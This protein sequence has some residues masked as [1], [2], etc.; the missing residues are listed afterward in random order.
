M[1][2][3]STIYLSVRECKLKVW[4]GLTWIVSWD[5]TFFRFIATN[6]DKQLS[7]QPTFHEAQFWWHAETGAWLRELKDA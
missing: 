3:A 4:S 5:Q 6:E 7:P 1:P 2:E